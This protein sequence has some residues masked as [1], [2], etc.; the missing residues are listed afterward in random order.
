MVKWSILDVSSQ[1]LTQ[2]PHIYFPVKFTYQGLYFGTYPGVLG[3]GI[4]WPVVKGLIGRNCKV[5]NLFDR[6]AEMEKTLG[7]IK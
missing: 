5:I 3:N 1:L 7:T 4:E 2:P 6:L